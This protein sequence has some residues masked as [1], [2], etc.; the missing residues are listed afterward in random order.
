MF[1]VYFNYSFWGWI[2][3]VLF[4]FYAYFTKNEYPDLKG[5]R[6]QLYKLVIYWS[7]SYPF[8]AG[9]AIVM[10]VITNLINQGGLKLVLQLLGIDWIKIDDVTPNLIPVLN[11]ALCFIFGASSEVIA[12]VLR[13][14]YYPKVE[15]RPEQ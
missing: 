11:K 12:N 5:F 15:L 7:K 3:L 4:N 9:S 1:W 2:V 14:R 13:R 10:F 8:L 6:R